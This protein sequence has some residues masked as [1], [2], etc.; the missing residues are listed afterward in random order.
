VVSKDSDFRLS[1]LLRGSR[2]GSCNR[3]WQRQQYRLT[4][5]VQHE[6][7]SDSL[8]ARREQLR[9]VRGGEPGSSRRTRRSLISPSRFAQEADVSRFALTYPR[10]FGVEHA[11]GPGQ[12]RRRSACHGSPIGT[13]AV[14]SRRK[15][16]RGSRVRH[17]RGGAKERTFEPTN[18]SRTSHAVARCCARTAGRPPGRDEMRR[19]G[20]SDTSSDTVKL[21]TDQKLGI[22]VPPSALNKSSQAFEAPVQLRGWRGVLRH[23][24][25][26]K[27]PGLARCSGPRT[28]SSSAGSWSCASSSFGSSPWRRWP[29][30]TMIV[31]PFQRSDRTHLPL[32]RVTELSRRRDPVVTGLTPGLL[33]RA[34]TRPRPRSLEPSRPRR[35]KPVSLVTRDYK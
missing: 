16:S 24:S 9:R 14:Q 15:T 18:P 35:V 13:S 12:V 19:R 27:P 10:R 28:S 3:D 2:V 20:Q 29:R 1:H 5:V 11:D 33:D 6:R 17:C 7:R 23:A 26:C 8:R 31:Q 4:W 25:L 32:E 22:R 34:L 21:P 30:S